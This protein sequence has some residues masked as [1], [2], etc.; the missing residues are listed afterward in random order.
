MFEGLYDFANLFNLFLVSTIALLV[1]YIIILVITSIVSPSFVKKLDEK[2]TDNLVEYLV[3]H[4]D[5]ETAISLM[6]IN[7]DYVQ[8]KG[9]SNDLRLGECYEKTGAYSNALKYYLD[10]YKL[11]HSEEIRAGIDSSTYK[12]IEYLMARY[13]CRVY[14]DMG[15]KT[16]AEEY[17]RIMEADYSDST[18][19]IASEFADHAAST[20]GVQPVGDMSWYSVDPAYYKAI[21]NYTDDP[22]GTIRILKD[23]I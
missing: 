4:Q 15:D 21:L 5:Y 14:I 1:V 20:L 7:P 12:S 11:L 23:V 8:K 3:S 13:I 17:L 10:N 2:M 18:M 16:R 9:Y 19:V 6:E 22:I